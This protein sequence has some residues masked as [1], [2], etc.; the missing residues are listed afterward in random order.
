MDFLIQSFTS[1]FRRGQSNLIKIICLAVGLSLGLVLIAKVCFEN[2]INS[3]FPDYERVYLVIEEYKHPNDKEFN[4]VHYIPGGVAKDFAAAIPQVELATRFT[5]VAYNNKVVIDEID[6]LSAQV[7]GADTCL[8]DMLGTSVIIG[9]P[10]SI[11]SA[12]GRVMVS[13]SM[14]EKMGGLDAVIGKNMRLED[15]NEGDNMSVAGVFEDLPE[16]CM[17]KAD[18]IVS[19]N[20]MGEWSV[21]NWMGNERYISFVKLTSSDTRNDV[22]KAMAVEYEKHVDKQLLI[23][24]GI[25]ARFV[26]MSLSEYV[27]CDAK[28]RNLRYLM[29][30]LGISLILISTLNYLL[31][32]ISTLVNRVKEVA[33]YKCYGAS[34]RF[35]L[36]MTLRESAF[37]LSLAL[38]LGALIIIATRGIAEELMNAT[39][40]SLFAFRT[41]V[42][43]AFVCLFLLAVTT[44]VPAYIFI[45]IPVAAA[46]RNFKESKKNWKLLLLFVQFAS[47]ACIVGL[48]TT[49]TW[50]YHYIETIDRGYDYNDILV[51]NC[52]GVSSEQQQFLMSEIRKM[53]DVECVSSCFDLPF[54]LS[55]NNVYLPNSVQMLF[56]IGDFY[57][58]TDDYFKV[59]GV[60]II[61]GAVFDPEADNSRTVMVSKRF[62]DRMHDIGEWEGSAV[63]RQIYV[64]E[65]CE[66]ASDLLTVVGVYSDIMV[67]RNGGFDERPTVIFYDGDD[68]RDYSHPHTLLI[69]M[70]NMNRESI[71]RI[72]SFLRANVT[73]CVCEASPLKELILQL[74]TVERNMRDAL[75]ICT[76]VAL[77]ISL[78]GLYGYTMDEVNR[79]RKEIAIRKVLGTT[80]LGIMKI[81]SKD[82]SYIAVPALLIGAMVAFY[83]SMELLSN[84]SERIDP[85]V[86]LYIGIAAG[87]YIV[88]MLCVAFQLYKA[89]N[90]NPVKNLK[91]E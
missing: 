74:L 6:H 13:R 30:F 52:V 91:A 80:S 47:T 35:L 85:G 51:A 73:R 60:D 20:V 59:M 87:I 9:D 7:I 65:H 70:H 27:D 25:E 79:R 68:K 54:G 49:V 18:V 33:V 63:G 42:V 56:N 16:T 61:D 72:N 62:V 71:D 58:V 81:I 2:S 24:A 66:S 31:I 28:D 43:I 78:L 19:I 21:N 15:M 14:A 57:N 36:G 76:I 38:I 8:F 37:H 40:E 53:P 45:K 39:L 29:L 55:G 82:V 1:L 48:L 12:P 46:F 67:T 69:R 32:V 5:P 10:K 3:F 22:L 88:I 77:I 17:F 4:Q 64:S 84:Y 86:L 44:I 89:A 26:L 50:Q 41:L 75:L 83:L 90:E 11:L 23:D 34:W